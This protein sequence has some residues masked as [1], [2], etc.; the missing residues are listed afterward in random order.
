MQIFS[1]YFLPACF[2][3]IFG[4]CSVQDHLAPETPQCRVSFVLNR[5]DTYLIPPGETVTIGQEVIGISGSYFKVSEILDLNGQ[6]YAI[7]GKDPLYRTGPEESNSSY[8]YD[9]QGRVSKAIY[10][11]RRP[12]ATITKEYEYVSPTELKITETPD[13]GHFPVPPSYTTSYALN[14]LGLVI[15]P[16]V[17]FDAEGYV[18]RQGSTTYTISNG[19]N[20]GTST[21]RFDF[22][23][24][25]PNPIP[26][27]LPFYGKANKNMRTDIVALNSEIKVEYEI[28]YIFD[29][30]GN[31]K[32][33]ILLI[34]YPDEETPVRVHINGYEWTCPK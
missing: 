14:S 34:N 4:S 1:R 23:I 7:S 3:L 21:E 8:E 17:T 26:N 25:K 10:R 19:N 2:I 29:D 6:L 32:Y 13:Y 30:Q 11:S 27:P 31:L 9:S 33:D 12:T 18:I 28:K 5:L 15:D 24:T 16:T 20:I 22:D